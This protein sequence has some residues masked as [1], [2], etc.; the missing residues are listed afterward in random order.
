M[1]RILSLL[2]F[3]LAGFPIACSSQN[4]E[5]TSPTDTTNT[6]QMIKATAT[7]PIS[8]PLPQT[9]LPT[10]EPDPTST[11]FITLPMRKISESPSE[12]R[13]GWK[14]DKD[15]FLYAET[16][17]SQWAYDVVSQQSEPYLSAFP[18]EPSADLLAQLPSNAEAIERSPSGAYGLYTTFAASATPTPLPDGEGLYEPYPAQLWF[19]DGEHSR[20][21]GM[22]EDCVGSYLWSANEQ[23]VAILSDAPPGMCHTAAAWILDL[24]SDK[25]TAWPAIPEYKNSIGISDINEEGSAVLYSTFGDEGNLY[26]RNL[27][28]SSDTIVFSRPGSHVFGLWLAEEQKLLLQSTDRSAN[29]LS[30]QTWIYDVT[31]MDLKPIAAPSPDVYISIRLLSPD[32]KW[33][34]FAT[35]KYYGFET[36]GLWIADL[37]ALP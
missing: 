30:F 29:T 36:D 34:A 10:L 9:I 8:L 3:V 21:L 22:V 19:W 6:P 11:P 17:S 1:R 5:Q 13:F 23:V 15:V 35:R 27:T 14:A 2:L 31:N 4:L 7:E 16:D 37:R 28:N 32:R 24:K 20:A 12:Y 18:W 25:L 33:L 26:I